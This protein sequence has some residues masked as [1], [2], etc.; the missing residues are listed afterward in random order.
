MKDLGNS[1]ICLRNGGAKLAFAIMLG[2]IV[3]FI[4]IGIFMAGMLDAIGWTMLIIALLAFGGIAIYLYFKQKTEID[5]REKGIIVQT[6]SQRHQILF[7][8]IDRLERTKRVGK[9]GSIVFVFYLLVIIK[10]DGERVTLPFQ[11]EETFMQRLLEKC[12]S[13]QN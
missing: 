8:D 2:V 10:K 7:A 12:S 4:G 3:L 6:L 1:L 13:L 9:S 11:V 5:L